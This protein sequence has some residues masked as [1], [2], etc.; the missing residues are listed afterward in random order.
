MRPLGCRAFFCQADTD[1]WQ[2]ELYE[3]SLTDLRRLHGEHDLPY[4]YMEW[5]YGLVQAWASRLVPSPVIVAT[6]AAPPAAAAAPGQ[7]GPGTGR[8]ADTGRLA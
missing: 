7:P 8:L 4:R 1:S 3:R 6:A 5:R 2:H